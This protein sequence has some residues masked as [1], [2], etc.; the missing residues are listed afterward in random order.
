MLF[1]Y[2]WLQDYVKEQLPKPKELEDLLLLHAFEVEGCEK[3]G[4]DWIFDIAVLPNRMPDAGSHRGMARE[5][6]AICNLS[7]Q[8]P[9]R[10]P[11]KTQKGSLKPISVSIAA[12]SF[13]PRYTAFVIEG[14]SVKR[15]PT[16]LRERIE[17][18]GGNSINT[19]VDLTN[20]IMLETG[21]PMHAFDYDK[22]QGAKM[23]V[24]MARKG[25]SLSL[26]D[27]TKV[28]LPEGALVIQDANRLIDL[29]GIMG[30]KNSAIDERT[31]NIVLQASTFDQTAIYIGKTK[32]GVQTQAAQLYASG[33][34]PNATLP[35]LERAAELLFGLGGGKIVQ[36]IDWY[37]QKTLPAKIALDI[38]YVHSLLGEEIPET[39][40]RSMLLRIGC[41]VRPHLQKKHMLVV[42]TPTRRKDLLC[43]EDCIE[44]IGRLFG[45]E[46]IKSKFPSSTLMPPSQSPELLWRE[47]VR[48]I[49]EAA[50][51]EETYNYSFLDKHA[52][53]IFGYEKKQRQELLELE[54]PLSE[55]YFYLR[56]NL[57]ENLLRNAARLAR[58]ERNIRLFEIGKAYWQSENRPQEQWRVAGLFA[59]GSFY[60]AKGIV[61]LL[62]ER[63]GITECW[64]DD[65]QQM[66]LQSAKSLWDMQ[67][68]AECKLGDNR[69]G[70]VGEISHPLPV[71]LKMHQNVAAFSLN[72]EALISAASAERAYQPPSRFPASVRD[73]AVL[74]P[75]STKVADVLNVMETKGGQLV[76][77]IDL[78]DM[79]EGERVPTGKK[80]LAF[81]IVYQS[82]EKTLTSEE[83][84]DLHGRIIK[85]IEQ[86][87]EWEV[88]K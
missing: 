3:E 67:R 20:Y 13:A 75:R 17:A 38:S 65:F 41:K 24:R 70:F 42:E 56:P 61:E 27:D 32:L 50:G 30:G 4:K 21:Q 49:L 19:I 18:T 40:I 2:N 88:R 66:P 46:N 83:I 69:I 47:Q 48:D 84:D 23:H 31:K 8:E 58:T 29:A 36:I 57:V 12:R 53:E 16:W 82:D 64:F 33:L 39:K 37:P 79:Y 7:Y 10:K 63:L 35:A 26:L 43:P 54:N 72:L 74:L 44:E 1:S 11:V 28:V 5:I 9:K 25:E 60:E 6:A 15:S 86:N 76:R 80:N 68:S 78:F 77:D 71:S 62:C 73:I 22:I 52:P 87:P 14:V 55:E 34:D 59:P 45:Y 81:H 51:L 85:A